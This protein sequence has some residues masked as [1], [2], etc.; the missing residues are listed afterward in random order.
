MTFSARSWI[1][2]S[3]PT[4]ALGAAFMK[5]QIGGFLLLLAGELERLAVA[6][7]C[8]EKTGSPAMFAS[9]VTLGSVGY[10]LAQPALGWLGDRYPRRKVL[11]TAFTLSAL[12]TLGLA[13]LSRRANFPVAAVAAI[14]LTG[15]LATATVPA[16]MSAVVADLVDKSRATDAFR[17]RASFSSIASIG[18]PI[19]AGTMIALFGYHPVLLGACLF[20]TLALVGLAAGLP[21]KKPAV[22]AGASS[23][24]LQFFR[25]WWGMTSYGAKAVWQIRPE[26][27]MGLLAMITNAAMLPLVL[28]VVP[29]LVKQ[30]FDDPAWVSGLA[31]A[32]L[33]VGVL[34][35]STFVIPK[36]KD[37][38][39][40]DAQVLLGRYLTA[41]GVLGTYL[42]VL[43]FGLPAV[44][45]ISQ[46]LLCLSLFAAGIGLGLVNIVGS[47]VRSRAIPP[48][49]RTRIFAATG[50]LS[51]VGIPLGMLLQGAALSTVGPKWSMFIVTAVMWASVGVYLS[52]GAIRSVMR[53]R[54]DELDGEYARRYP[55]FQ[56]EATPGSVEK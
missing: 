33:G 9:M 24:P 41:A 25:Q 38:L 10:L 5:V 40:H 2:T 31:S 44:K 4:N 56:A 19:A 21:V 32:S 12:C 16:L 54:D 20:V 35:C 28:V 14:L 18:G 30:Y 37:T 3:F 22:A 48:H 29:A 23:G 46:G 8:L 26:R 15:S 52:C 7:W 17:V 43:A 34:A 45:D 42:S 39:S 36:I 53:M 50:F 55:Q 27:Q 49:L 47:S 6:W 11:L 13:L 1:S 51:G